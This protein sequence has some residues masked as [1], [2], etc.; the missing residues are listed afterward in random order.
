MLTFQ[1][2]LNHYHG[3]IDDTVTL[4]F[5]TRQKARIKTVTDGGSDIGI[6]IERCW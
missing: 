2:R 5:D 4:D 6:F 3:D 1:E